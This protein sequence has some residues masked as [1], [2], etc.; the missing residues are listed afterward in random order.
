MAAAYP[1]FSGF[2]PPRSEAIHASRLTSLNITSE[3]AVL[4]IRH[5]D[6]NLRVL[7]VCVVVQ[8]TD[9]VHDLVGVQE[10]SCVGALIFLFAHSRR[11]HSLHV[12]L[13]T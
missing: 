3:V 7:S 11:L 8:A 5:P 4:R 9:C 13:P 12:E 1:S 6:A 2:S 10:D